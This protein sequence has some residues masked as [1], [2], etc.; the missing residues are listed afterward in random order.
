MMEPEDKL[1][2]AYKLVCAGPKEK[3]V[4]LHMIG[5]G[6]EE[7]LQG[8]AVAIKMGSAPHLSFSLCELTFLAFAATNKEFLDTVPIHPTSAEGTFRPS[9]PFARA[10]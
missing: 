2:T 8:F 6:S 9:L 7:I 3:V 4:G 10:R 1:P 5:M